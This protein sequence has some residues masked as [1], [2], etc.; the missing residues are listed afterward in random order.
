MTAHNASRRSASE[1]VDQVFLS[2]RVVD[3]TAFEEFGTALRGLLEEAAGQARAVEAAAARAEQ[4]QRRLGDHGPEVEAR[5]TGAANALTSAEAKALE[6]KA[7][8][9]KATDHLAR[10]QTF[11][12]CVETFLRE[13]LMAFQAKLDEAMVVHGQ[14]VLSIND[15]A[16]RRTHELESRVGQLA[17]RISQLSRDT[18]GALGELDARTRAFQRTTNSAEEACSALAQA[19]L[20]A[21]GTIES[22]L[23][24][25]EALRA[26]LAIV[27]ERI[28]ALQGNLSGVVREAREASARTIELKPTKRRRVATPTPTKTAAPA[29][30]KAKAVA[31]R[32]NR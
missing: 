30:V 15:E 13:R 10:A 17:L 26:E 14:R 32:K 11:E 9:T 16:E 28:R 22:C 20:D 19:T 6:A 2:P 8:L 31:S 7:M 5:I 23:G 1:I 3:R 12:A 27:S 25:R 21:V 18:E 29:K 4:V 24:T